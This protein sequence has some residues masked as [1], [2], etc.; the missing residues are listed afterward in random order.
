L[1][2]GVAG[3]LEH[4]QGVLGRAGGKEGGRDWL[5]KRIRTR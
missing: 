4:G 5:I 2:A 1:E 3:L